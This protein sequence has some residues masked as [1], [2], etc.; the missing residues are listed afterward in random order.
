M[1]KYI[2]II[3]LGILGLTI[4]SCEKEPSYNYPAGHVGDSKITVYAT[5]VLKG[6]K[7][8]LL[9]KGTAFTDPG[10]TALEGTAA[11]TPVVKGAVDVNTPGVYPI[12]Y[13]ATNSDGFSIAKTRTVIVYD[14]KADAVGNDFS[15]T[16]SIAEGQESV[17]TKLAAGVYSVTD[18]AGTGSGVALIAF[19]TTGNTIH[20]PVQLSDDG[21]LISTK[22]ESYD[23]VAGTYSWSIVNLEY[24]P[25]ALT[26][27]KQ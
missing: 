17:W 23:P 2:A 24:Q 12:T 4:S 21:T 18:P 25:D 5:V 11:L 8:V 3:G 26:F 10:V 15:G 7:T 1:K 27:V 20:V 13:T 9:T 16:Y 14:T 6:D 19:N 22:N